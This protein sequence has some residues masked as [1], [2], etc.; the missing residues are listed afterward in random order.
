MSCRMLSAFCQFLSAKIINRS[1]KK[2]KNIILL[3][4]SQKKQNFSNHKF[5]DYTLI[6]RYSF[7]VNPN[8]TR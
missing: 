4:F 6:F 2:K 1:K 5:D 7:Y 3:Y 8:Q